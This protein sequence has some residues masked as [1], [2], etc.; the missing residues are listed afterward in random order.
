M[1]DEYEVEDLWIKLT[2][3][4]RVTHQMDGLL[5]LD[6]PS[7]VEDLLENYRTTN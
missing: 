3:S 7:Y 6:E 1:G 4:I 5:T 2:I